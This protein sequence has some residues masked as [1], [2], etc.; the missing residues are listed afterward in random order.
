MKPRPAL[1]VGA[2]TLVVTA[3]SLALLDREPY[4]DSY[5]FK[6]TA[7]NFLD[8]GVLAW[9][10]AEGPVYGST[11]QLFQLVMVGIT[12]IT[13]SYTF[14]ATRLFLLACLVATL[15]I[16]LRL[17]RARD[18]GFAAV[19]ACC[20]PV[21]LFTAISGM[22]TALALLSVT[23][24]LFFAFDPRGR[25]MPSALAPVCVALVWL[26]RPDAAVLVLPLLIVA[27][28]DGWPVRELSL[29]AVLIVVSLV[30]CKVYYGT[31]LPLPFYAKQRMFSPYDAHFLAVSS[32]LVPVRF[33]H[34][35][36]VALPLLLA[37]LM[38]R[39]RVNL[40]LLASVACFV[41]YHLTS[42]IEIMGMIGRFYAP[43]LPVLTFAAA[44]GVEA[45]P[46]APRDVWMVLACLGALVAIAAFLHAT[47]RG[48]DRVRLGNYVCIGLAGIALLAAAP[49]G[50]LF[51][52]GPP[53]V[54][55]VIGLVSLSS[56]APLKVRSDDAY[57]TVHT[58]K[59]TV[60][61]GLDTLRRCFGDAIHVYHSEVGVPGLRFIHGTVTDLAGLLSP[62]WLFRT[63]SF[64]TL[65]RRD[66]PEAIFLPHKNYQRLNAEIR[67][68]ECITG[69]Q[70]MVDESSSPL[71]VRRDLAPAF[72]IC[73]NEERAHAVTSR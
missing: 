44:R 57:L 39:D 55:L 8:H 25:A 40:T 13:R 62:A 59:F 30:V 50:R 45:R 54:M 38:R 67:A 61:R 27:R 69:Y 47:G 3:F 70:R 24:V 49:A 48:P 12:A 51:R 1:L 32:P 4:D 11:S 58:S 28:A 34:F 63:A 15:A 56:W 73:R 53:V 2:Y 46:P 7:L 18:G 6:R 14:L 65:C 41:A 26:T 20:S 42:T 68:G 71:Y 5:F 36:F 52:A 29:A 66:R 17:T 9:N 10:V 21:V 31:A 37:A 22:E 19:I 16:L 60:Y 35:A 23:V 43:A 33:G 64:D 72:L